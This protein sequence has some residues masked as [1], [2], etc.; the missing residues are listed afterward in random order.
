MML[1][2]NDFRKILLLLGLIIIASSSEATNEDS[3]GFLRSWKRGLQ[4]ECPPN[5]LDACR[6]GDTC[7]QTIVPC[8]VWSSTHS[9]CEEGPMRT[10]ECL[11]M[12]GETNENGSVQSEWV[13]EFPH[14]CP[15]CTAEYPEGCP[16]T[17]LTRFDRNSFCP[18]NDA[19]CTINLQSCPFY[20]EN[21]NDCVDTLITGPCFCQDNKWNCIQISNCAPCEK[22]TEFKCPSKPLTSFDIG[23]RCDALGATCPFQSTTVCQEWNG[24]SCV[25]MPPLEAF[26]DCVNSQWICPEVACPIC[27]EPEDP[28]CP[29]EGLDEVEVLND[30]C[31]PGQTCKTNS[32]CNI[33]DNS[34]ECTPTSTS[35]PC[36]C[37]EQGT[38]ECNDCL[39][40]CEVSTDCSVIMLPEDSQGK[41]CS[42]SGMVCPR[43][44]SDICEV[45]N[46]ETGKCSPKKQESECECFNGTWSCTTDSCQP[47]EETTMDESCPESGLAQSHQSLPCS[48]IGESCPLMDFSCEVW[49][50]KLQSCVKRVVEASCTCDGNWVCV[51]PRCPEC[52]PISVN[53]PSPIDTTLSPSIAPTVATTSVPV[54]SVPED[55]ISSSPNSD[56]DGSFPSQDTVGDNNEP[57]LR[58]FATSPTWNLLRIELV[59][60]LGLLRLQ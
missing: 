2:V 9:T 43:S 13:C 42:V 40:S 58:S 54:S 39:S 25:D 6:V 12:E 46:S 59:L 51:V 24:T 14:P 26:C 55:T 3:V 15:P 1:T 30:A 8:Q 28:T 60:L 44:S 21:A 16:V 22:P 7:Q 48:P 41:E 20:D 47:C 17:N 52:V 49:D 10:S 57:D 27:A 53:T 5:P 31:R 18:I 34:G 50:E 32:V 11:C 35:I 36:R 29:P 33:L 19:Q 45:L 4:N 56:S 23:A 37:T 38:W